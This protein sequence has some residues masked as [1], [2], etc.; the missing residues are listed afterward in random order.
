MWGIN[1][2]KFA[3]MI[4][5][6]S[7]TTSYSAWKTKIIDVKNDV[8]RYNSIAIDTNNRIYISYF[9][10]TNGNLKCAKYDGMKWKVETIDSFGKVGKYTDIALGI[11]NR[12]FISYYD[13]TNK[14]YKLAEWTGSS[15]T[16]K[17]ID[18]VPNY[19]GR[20]SLVVNS[21]GY[22]RV[23]YRLYDT[24]YKLKLA[25]WT[26]TKWSTETVDSS[27]YPD[28]FFYNSLVLDSTGYPHIAYSYSPAF[29][30]KEIKYAKW[31]GI[32]WTTTSIDLADYLLSPVS[33]ALDANNYPHI[34][35]EGYNEILKYA[36]WTGTE[37][38]TQTIDSVECD[39]ISITVDTTGYPH[40]SYFDDTNDLLKY[41]YWTGTE[42]KIEVVDC[43]SWGY[44]SLALDTND[45]P[46]LSYGHYDL[47]YAKFIP[48]DVSYYGV[49]GYIMDS[50]EEPISGVTV[51][52]Y[53]GG[54]TSST[55]TN[56]DGFYYLYELS[57]ASTHTI[58]PNKEG[59]S[60]DPP[61]RTYTSLNRTDIDENFR[62]IYWSVI[63]AIRG[64][65]ADIYG[66][67]IPGVV[68]M[69]SGDIFDT[70]TTV[71]DGYFEFQ[72]LPEGNYTISCYKEH[73]DFDPYSRAY[74]P[75]NSDRIEQNFIGT[76]ITMEIPEEKGKVK[77]PSPG[78]MKVV[79]GGDS[80]GIIN[81]DKKHP[82]YV[83]YNAKESGEVVMRVFNLVGE[84]V[85][86]EKKQTS[87][88][89]GYFRW[90]PKELSSGT[91]IIHVGGAGVNF[92][93]KLIIVR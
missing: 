27:S 11:D 10:D 15:W 51:T 72:N 89:G 31:T 46:H 43:G 66:N 74:T 80:K 59:W 45:N 78:E 69:L 57:S 82:V 33:I 67:P 88:H 77:L 12:P 2:V 49:Y 38:S 32:S 4:L 6:I 86:T 9:D 75:L 40:I 19:P 73:W 25:K 92:Y 90:I 83:V 48:G 64:T 62:G 16:I 26:G 56:E 34:A 7:V 20:T 71:D 22:P 35:Y 81:P 24:A 65:V 50:G 76:Q 85:Y 79:G 61:A 28:S 53:S 39:D 14:T 17:T 42:W 36:K 41:T 52:V 93:Q 68:V 8:G 60:F 5:A 91:Y 44:N 70:R 21:T 63:Y 1:K 54:K 47:L 18:S 84:I 37:W 87:P 3:F 55:I 29:G 23:S 58:V 13:D 30:N